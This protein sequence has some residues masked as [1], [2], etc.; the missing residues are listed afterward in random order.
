MLQLISFL[1]GILT[2][3]VYNAL[4]VGLAGLVVTMLAVVPPWPFYNRNPVT[5]LA[6]RKVGGFFIEP[7]GAAKKSS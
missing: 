6:P 4:Y 3:S 7:V 1:V 2:S 5:W